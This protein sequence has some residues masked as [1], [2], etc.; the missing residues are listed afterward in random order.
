MYTVVVI[1]PVALLTALAA[2][3]P[4]SSQGPG[5]GASWGAE[6]P[7]FESVG[8]LREA[9]RSLREM[10]LL[11]LLYPNLLAGLGSTPG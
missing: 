1:V 5:T 6:A 11:P 3:G 7:G 4:S 10:V 9:V 2:G 8:G